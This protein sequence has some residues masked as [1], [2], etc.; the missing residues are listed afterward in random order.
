MNILTRFVGVFFIISRDIEFNGKLRHIPQNS[1]FFG[2]K[3][4][5]QS[6]ENLPITLRYQNHFV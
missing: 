1:G 5:R 4:D 2:S 6:I 3:T